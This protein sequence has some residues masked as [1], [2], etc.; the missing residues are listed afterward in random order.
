MDQRRVRVRSG[1][2]LHQVKGC[3]T[4][5]FPAVG[6]G[7]ARPARIVPRRRRLSSHDPRI[8]GPCCYRAFLLAPRCTAFNVLEIGACVAHSLWPAGPAAPYIASVGR[9]CVVPIKGKHR[10][11]SGASARSVEIWIRPSSTAAG[12][13]R[14]PPAESEKPTHSPTQASAPARR[15]DTRRL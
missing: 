12:R 8:G 2:E 4:L 11:P 9:L 7:G 15:I 3:P 6:M 13:F 1:S 14:F 10:A 5:A